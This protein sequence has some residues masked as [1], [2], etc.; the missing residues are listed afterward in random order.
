MK[1][2]Y[3]REHTALRTRCE[4]H[5]PNRLVYFEIS[6]SLFRRKLKCV[7]Q[8]LQRVTGVL[9]HRQASFLCGYNFPFLPFLCYNPLGK[10][11]KTC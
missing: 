9:N 8:I 6:A 5:K 3:S 7:F 10:D 2:R 1:V 4:R 11:V